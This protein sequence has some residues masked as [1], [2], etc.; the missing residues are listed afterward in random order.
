VI[1]QDIKQYIKQRGEAEL[2]DIALHFDLEPEALQGMLDFWIR[3]GRIQHRFV[4]S[5]CAGSCDC[6]VAEGRHLYRWNPQ[7]GNVSI[8]ISPEG[9]H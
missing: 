6:A 9:K 1:L 7:L 2:G 4:A 5:E 3:K 8:D